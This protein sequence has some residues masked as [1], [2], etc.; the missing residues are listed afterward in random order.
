VIELELKA[1]VPDPRALAARLRAAG[2]REVFTGKL[3]DRR[4][5]FADG[6]L[7]RRDEVVRVREY[8]AAGGG[9][10]AFLE[11]KGPTSIAAGYKRRDEI[12]VDLGDAET[13]VGILHRAG[14]RVVRT[15]DRDIRQFELD[16]ATVR[17]EHYPGMDDLVEVE[18]EPAAIE[19]AIVHMGI[20]R[21]EFSTDSLTEFVQRYEARTGRRA[22]T[23]SVAA[24]GSG[25]A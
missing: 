16:G 17:L 12:G 22:S 25:H 6:S 24:G 4:L 2:A 21:G 19:R 8:R 20:A 9:S 13:G 15:I 3:I 7:L 10:K 11:W 23:G 5:D 1:V 18:G 14:L